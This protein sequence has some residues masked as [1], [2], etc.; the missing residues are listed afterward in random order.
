MSAALLLPV[1]ESLWKLGQPWWEFVLRAALVYGFLLGI[2]RLTG[3]RQVSQM[4]PFDLV[5]LLVLSNAVQNS[6]NAGDNTVTAGLVLVTAL[7]A[8]NAAM[9]WLTFRFK[10]VESLVEGQPLLLVHNGA[11]IPAA[12]AEERVT[13]HE[14]MAALR[15]VGLTS[16]DEVHVAVLESNGH[17]SVIPRVRTP[18]A[19]GGSGLSG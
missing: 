10:R 8:I 14:L 3:K 7:V 13:R 17:I 9:G 12:L 15:A 4:S 1:G 2:L 16:L 5:L 18:E 19:P 6:M 11:V